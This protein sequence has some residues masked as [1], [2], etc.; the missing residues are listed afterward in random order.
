[1]SAIRV[2]GIDH[3]VLRVT[4]LTRSLEFYCGVLGCKVERTV[5]EIGLVQ[6][7][8]GA[9]LVDL[10]DVAGSLGRAGGAPAGAEARNLD[11]FALRIEFFDEGDLRAHLAA[12]GVG[13]GVVEMRYGAE[14]HGPSMYINDPDGNTVE[15]KGPPRGETK[16]E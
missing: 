6:L 11:H 13:A 4:D 8:A 3:L 9:A 15:L 5:E 1:M 12:H 14:G 7:R 2:E 10:V 16:G